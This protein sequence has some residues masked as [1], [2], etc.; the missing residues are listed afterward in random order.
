[1]KKLLYNQYIIKTYYN[2][3]ELSHQNAGLE[4]ENQKLEKTIENFK[5]AARSVETLEK[6]L[7]NLESAKD[8]QERNNKTSN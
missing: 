2:T 5:N 4:S 7:Y 6:E 8:D 1:M 3:E